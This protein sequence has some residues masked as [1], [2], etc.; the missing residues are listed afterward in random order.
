[1]APDRWRQ[2]EKIYYAALEEEP[3]QRTFF[4]DQACAD[5]EAL[6]AEVESLLAA[7][8]RATGF[9]AEP[10]VEAEAKRLAAEQVDLPAGQDLGQYQI[11]GRLGAGAMGIVYLTHDTKLGRKVA[12]KVLP[13]R[14]TEDEGRLRRFLREAKAASALNHPNIVTVYETGQADGLHFIAAEFI[15]G[16]TLRE[17]M[18]RGPIAPQEAVEIA[19]QIAAALD[20]AHQAGIIHRDIKPENVMLRLDSLVKVLDFG[21]AKLIEPDAP[22]SAVNSTEHGMVMGTPRYMSP[23]Q[24]RGQRLDART[25]VFSLGVVLYEMLM[26]HPPFTGDTT[27]DLF[28]SLLSTEPEPLAHPTLAPI[29]NKA[30]AKDCNARYQTVKGLLQDLQDCKLDLELPALIIRSGRNKAYPPQPNPISTGRTPG[31]WRLNIRRYRAWAGGLAA[32]LILAGMVLW[33]VSRRPAPSGA[34]LWADLNISQFSNFKLGS[35]EGISRIAVSP[36]GER[37]AYSLSSEEGSQIWIGEFKLKESKAITRDRSKDQG[38][39]WSPDGQRLAFISDRGGRRGIWSV[40]YP[41]GAPSL[42]KDVDLGASVFL[43]CWAR[44]DKTIYYESNSNLNKLDLDSGQTSQLTNFGP[45]HLTA[46]NFRVSPDGGQ[47]A[48]M[49]VVNGKSHVFV[50]PLRG[51][52]PVQVTRGEWNDKAPDWLPDGQR[53]AYISDRKGIYQIYLS[54]LEGS[55]PVQIPFGEGD[56]D[57]LAVSPKGSKAVSVSKR[58]N[59]NLFSYDLQTGEE[60]EQ[61]SDFGLQLFP[62]VSPD[63]QWLAFQTSTTSIR[64]DVSIYLRS[65]TH[66]ATPHQLAAGFD[67]KWS[68]TGKAL[69]FLRGSLPNPELWIVPADGGG[70]KRLTSGGIWFS[71]R[72]GVPYNDLQPSFSWAPDGENLTYSSEKSGQMNLWKVRSDGAGEIMI[73][74]NTDPKVWLTAPLWAPDGKHIAYLI[75]PIGLYASGKERSV[76]M[77]TETGAETKV[78]FSAP[79]PLRLVGWS[80]SGA[81]LYLALGERKLAAIPQEV[82]LLRL[83]VT[84]GKETTIAVIPAAYLHNIKLSPDKRSVALVSRQDGKDNISLVTISGGRVKQVSRNSDLKIY[85]SGLAW[86]PDGKTLYYSKQAN[87]ASISVF[88]NIR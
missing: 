13:K 69:A 9:L 65:L 72:T 5:D 61:T 28:A 78:I 26:G 38:P 62:D 42:L 57:F 79:M 80:A 33:N 68:P 84:G 4:L 7:P 36:D 18:A 8:E 75:E 32:L 82:S 86:S 17:R 58:E 24:A 15:E 55:A 14:F 35:G 50:L 87:W 1:M 20:A 41:N 60:V 81:E 77:T 88:D 67:M 56:Y 76:C 6:R 43:V 37:I 73:S 64:E 45:K 30:L 19:L 3:E 85:Y 29:V 2:V 44:D 54:D 83:P 40:G 25:D 48:Y 46:Q 51:G 21:L 39:I 49:D 10:A 23:E 12:L 47:V 11:L 16:E 34:V 66:G 63:G 52:A 31:D 59:A 27:A 74:Q 71:G 53:L 70:E 22:A